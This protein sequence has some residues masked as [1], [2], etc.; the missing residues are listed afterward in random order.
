MFQQAL[1]AQRPVPPQQT[2]TRTQDRSRKSRFSIQASQILS[3][4]P[5]IINSAGGERARPSNYQISSL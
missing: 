1:V 4:K 2:V 3:E 5:A